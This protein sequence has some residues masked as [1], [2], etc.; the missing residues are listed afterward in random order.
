MSNQLQ[1]TGGAKVRALEGVITGTS[2]VLGSVP[3]GAAN[4]V[5]TLDSGGKV[6]VSQLPSSVVTYLGTWNAA[7]NTP[8]LTNGVGDAG[9][10]YICNVAGTVNFG[11]GPVTFAVGDWVLYGSG[12]WQKSNGQNGTVTS[13]GATI[14]G[15]AIG[16]TGSPITTAGTLAFAF[17]G[18]SGQYVNGAGNLTTFPSLTGYV[19]YTGA[20]NDLNLGTH[21]LYANN[22]FDGFINVAASGSQIVLT[23]ASAPSYTITG[24]GGQTIKLP[25]ATTLPNGAIF[26]FNNNQSSGAITINNNS[27]TL[28]VSVPSGGFAEVVLLD[29]SIAAGSWD[30]HFK[31]P[32]NVSW[33]TNTLDYAGSITSAT[34]NGNVVA[35]NRGGTGSSTQNFVDLT[36]TQTIGGAK[37]FSS[38]LTASSL[39]KTGGTSSQFLKA[40]G[41]VDSSSY[42][43]LGSLSFAAGSG[44]Y[45]S[46]TGVIT[47]PTNNTQIT[48][49]ANYIT[50]GSLSAGVGISYNNTTGVITSTITQY[51]DAL[52]RAAISLTTTGTSGA[53]TY[54]STTGVLNIPQYI[55]GV[56]S[57]FGRTGAVV[58]TEG[59]Y[60]LTQL[61]DVT[62]TSP[63]TGQALKYNGTGW[64]NGTDTD[65]GITTINTLTA[66]T[67]TFAVGTSGTDFAISSATSTHTFNLPTASATNRGALSSA[68]WST[69][70]GKQAALSGTGFV[71]ISGTTISYD[72]ST[73]YLASNPS[74]F[75]SL[76]ALSSSATGLTYTNTTGVFSFTA[77]YSIPTNASQTN[78]DTA[79][80][81][82]IST[83]NGLTAAT[84]N[85]STGASGSDFNISSVSATHTFN[86]P[87][88]SASVTGKLSSTDW[89]TFNNKQSAL[90]NPVTYTGTPTTNY[91]PKFTG[92]STI[93]NS[94]VSE[95][96]GIISIAGR[97]SA[98]GV[99]YHSLVVAEGSAQLRLERTTSSTGVMYLGADNV[100]FKI[101]DSAFATRL[102]LTSG[103][104]LGLGVTPSA[105]G[106][107]TAIQV[108]TGGAFYAYQNP[109]E[110]I[111]IVNNGYFNG[112][113]W[114]YT[115]SGSSSSRY[116]QYD[117][118]HLF[119]NA[120]SGTA[121]NAITFTQAMT[122]TAAGRLL[123]GTPYE[124]TY[125]LDV[126]GTGRFSGSLTGNTLNSSNGS[127]NLNAEYGSG[128]DAQIH[129]KQGGYHDWYIKTPAGNNPMQFSVDGGSALFSLASTGA[130]TFSSSVT[131]SGTITAKDTTNDASVLMTGLDGAYGLI[132]ANNAAGSLTKNLVLQKYGGNVGIGT[133]S[134]STALEVSSSDLNNI[135]VTNPTTSG[136]TT[137]SGIGFKAYNGSS[138]TQYGGIILTS[139]TWSY[140]TYSAQQLS[141]GVDGTGGLALRSANSAPIAFFTGGSSA[142]VST[143]RM[144][145]TSDGKLL[146]G[147]Q[148]AATYLLDVN[149][150]GRFSG[151]V[152]S[153]GSGTAYSPLHTKSSGG[154]DNSGLTI[155]NTGSGGAK[156]YVW[157]TAT[158]N[159]EGANKLIFSSATTPNI[160]ILNGST[161]A[162]TF[163]SS[164]TASNFYT[165]SAVGYS[166]EFYRNNNADSRINITNTTTTSGGDK[167]LMLGEIGVDSY[168]YNYANGA[169]IF[170]TNS[171]ERMRI[172]SG[173]SV[174]IGTNTDDTSKL[175]VKGTYGNLTASFSGVTTT[176]GSFGIGIA[177]GTNTSDY[178][179][180]ISNAA[181]NTQYF[182]VTGDGNTIIGNGGNN[183]FKLEVN[184]TGKFTGALGIGNSVAT[185]V[186]VASTHKVSILIGG[187]QYYLLASNV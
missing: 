14:T 183:G 77:G 75:I 134:P 181:A 50:L 145:I 30:R 113:G 140:G 99:D 177:A 148:T 126:N 1:I 152:L 127:I 175:Q 117:G 85:F 187:V 18:T 90:T 153:G 131:S 130:A 24:S 10:M 9:D 144:R 42:I 82:R 180:Y 119:Y 45:N 26:S 111:G 116:H 165:S 67:Q 125:M 151:N 179:M 39:I 40:D 51:T 176:G 171:T 115:N 129:F 6:P 160:L 184:G 169:A 104:N 19:P 44:A 105:W 69:F 138:V 158:I 36:T 79:Y 159:G 64:V 4:G 16:I 135:F 31:A 142:G 162:A 20:T 73:Y 21:N 86:L 147:T 48:N 25:D 66:L 27:N 8:T 70:N 71:K 47:I 136:A 164:V 112:S 46:T 17:A 38:S 61:G 89:T 161:G 3:L 84:Q 5:A 137:G 167:G 170:G 166:A 122:L 11:A 118:Q 88:A 7:T 29:N 72:N 94:I 114:I 52:A 80:N 155:E 185:A 13:V 55:G 149:G 139:N 74:A 168:F 49:G 78:W 121:G 60:T 63:T 141:I 98:I 172:T 28:V 124:S 57:V 43:T 92:A 143:E 59:D 157:P 128:N 178:A 156:F 91:L 2:G 68:D 186:S 103:G 33:S 95:S 22:I 37:T 32:S 56:T 132:Q 110:Q 123:I 54:N 182:K 106:T 100:G 102:T 41:S 133:P 81:N 101:F 93:G 163:S 97:L 108:T 120:P 53:A 96:G 174:L 58:A 65:T 15:G 87:T 154:G 34:W 107:F 150:T 146:L 23:I 109:F 62:I 83:L 173:G 35:I 12:T 76:L